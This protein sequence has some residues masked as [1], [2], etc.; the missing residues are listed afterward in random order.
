MAGLPGSPGRRR[1]GAEVEAFGFCGPRHFCLGLTGRTYSG[2][3]ELFLAAPV[4][5]QTPSIVE[6]LDPALDALVAPN[7]KVEKIHEDASSSKVPA[8]TAL[9]SRLGRC[10]GDDALYHGRHHG[11]ASA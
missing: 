3:R 1:N 4:V 6:R 10:R 2:E 7:A 8:R 11:D 9:E 5:V